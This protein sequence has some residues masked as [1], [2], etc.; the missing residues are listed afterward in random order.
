MGMGVGG[1]GASHRNT[2]RGYRG[3]QFTEINVTPFVDVML[4]LLIIFMVT[5]PML[6]AGVVVDLPQSAAKPVPGND[7]PLTVSVNKAGDIFIQETPT[8]L[9]DLGAKLQAITGE[10]TETRIFIRG[11]KGIDYGLV[12]KVIGEINKAGLLKV[13]LISEVQG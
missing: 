7:E 1:G 11:D 13:A 9:E 12:M 10:K 3:Q 5:A 8:D 2:G 6:T 4:V